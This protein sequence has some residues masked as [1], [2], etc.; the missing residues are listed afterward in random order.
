MGIFYS[1]RLCIVVLLLK[2]ILLIVAEGSLGEFRKSV[3]LF[4][5]VE[6]SS[7]NLFPV[8]RESSDSYATFLLGQ[9]D[10]S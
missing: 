9:N 6:H 3:C 5:L 2:D 4:S 1:Y 10:E 7:P 8:D